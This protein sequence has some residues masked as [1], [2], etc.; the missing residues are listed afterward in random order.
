[1][2]NDPTNSTTKKSTKSTEKNSANGTAKNLTRLQKKFL[3]R[4]AAGKNVAEAAAACGIPESSAY[5]E[6][7]KILRHPDAFKF[8]TEIAV[9]MKRYDSD[10]VEESLDRIINGRINDAVILAKSCPE[11]LTEADVRKLDL[12][13]VSELKFSKGVCEIKF[14]DRIKAIEKLNEIRTGRA[15][16]NAAQSFLDAINEAGEN[17]DDKSAA[18]PA[19]ED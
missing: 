1:M 13:N 10:S 17:G 3:C 5:E 6:G 8:V 15:A 7:I 12:Y 16:D 2:P 4:F 14:A 19:E 9:T 11:E 18:P